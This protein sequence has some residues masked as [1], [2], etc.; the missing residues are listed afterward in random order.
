MIHTEKK[1]AYFHKPTK[2]WA[3]IVDFRDPYGRQYLLFFKKDFD[4]KLLYSDKERLKRNL[5]ES[6]K[7]GQ[8]YAEENFLDF[9][10]KEFNV[11]YEML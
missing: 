8:P 7:A 2:T 5:L 9:E 10:L 3:L 4:S 1:F 6:K 11:N